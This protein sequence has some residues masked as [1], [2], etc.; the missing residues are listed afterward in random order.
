MV[1]TIKMT[2]YILILCKYFTQWTAVCIIY[3]DQYLYSTSASFFNKCNVKAD[4]QLFISILQTVNCLTD[5]IC[6]FFNTCLKLS[7][8]FCC[9]SLSV[10]FTVCFRMIALLKRFRLDFNDV[11]VM[12]DSEK[13]PHSK[14]YVDKTLI[15]IFHVTEQVYWH[16]KRSVYDDKLLYLPPYKFFKCDLFWTLQFS[17]NNSFLLLVLI[18]AS[19][20]LWTVSPPSCCMMN[21]RNVSQ[22]R[23]WDKVPH[24]KYLTNSLRPSDL[25]CVLWAPHIPNMCNTMLSLLMSSTV[26]NSSVYE[27]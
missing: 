25:R 22:F 6:I 11:I 14:K 19:I 1:H 4:S 24:G 12:T 26:S 13:H 5:V 17:L 10:I 16:R 2:L 8:K 21:S 27:K 20:G 23:R 7:L 3:N 18:S 15:F 9:N